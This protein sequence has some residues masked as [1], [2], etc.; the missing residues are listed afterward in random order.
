MT[1]FIENAKYNGRIRNERLIILKQL[2]IIV[3]V[4][5]YYGCLYEWTG[6]N[7]ENTKI[8]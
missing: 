2:I 3:D 4:I 8:W 7:E 6:M 1:L 5:N